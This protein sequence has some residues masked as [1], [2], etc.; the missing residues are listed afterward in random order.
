VALNVIVER[1]YNES[2]ERL[3]RRFVKKVKRDGVLEKYRE[4]CTHYVKPSVKRKIKSKKARQE[5]ERLER[6][7]NKR[8]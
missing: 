6:K 4:R 2:S 1:R 7:R 3:I 5:K 8:K